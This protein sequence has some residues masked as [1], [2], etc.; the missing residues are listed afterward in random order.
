[1]RL[2]TMFLNSFVLYLPMTDRK[3]RGEMKPLQNEIDLSVF[4]E[5]VTMKKEAEEF[6][7]SHSVDTGKVRS[8]QNIILNCDYLLNA[9]PVSHYLDI[10]KIVEEGVGK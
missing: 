7:K 8:K 6:L 4:R 3:D 10:V 5:I 1:M 2:P 9:D